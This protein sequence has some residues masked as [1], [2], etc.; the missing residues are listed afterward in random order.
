MP[1]SSGER[2][3]VRFRPFSGKSVVMGMRG[4]KKRLE[5]SYSK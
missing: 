3:C 5:R 1:I 4:R 2:R